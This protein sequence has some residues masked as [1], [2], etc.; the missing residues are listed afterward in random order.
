MPVPLLYS[1]TASNSMTSSRFV[2]AMALERFC[3]YEGGKLTSILPEVVISAL[4]LLV[5]HNRGHL[6]KM[7]IAASRRYARECSRGRPS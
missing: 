3:C 2:K 1:L 4:E 7:S 6:W 5:I